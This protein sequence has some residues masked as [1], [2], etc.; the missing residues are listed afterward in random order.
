MEGLGVFFRRN[1]RCNAEKVLEATNKV[2]AGLGMPRKSL[3][4]RYTIFRQSL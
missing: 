1:D 2:L 4:V 3:R